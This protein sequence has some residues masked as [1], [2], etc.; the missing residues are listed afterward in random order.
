MSDKL[1]RRELSWL[2]TQEARGAAE[3]LRRGV[4]ILTAR[5]Q[6]ATPA[7]E[8][9]S[10]RPMTLSV[11]GEEGEGLESTLDMLD[12]AMQRLAELSGPTAGRPRRGRIDLAALLW[13]VAPGAKVQLEPGAGTTVLADE[14]ELRRMLHVLL[15]GSQQP[16]VG[17]AQRITLKREGDE[18]RLGVQL[19]PDVAPVSPAERGWLSRM[20]VRYGGRY[21]LDGSKE[22]VVFPALEADEAHEVQTL[23]RELEAAKAQ[24]EMYARELAAVFAEDPTRTEPPRVEPARAG[25]DATAGLQ[26]AARLADALADDLR[27]LF[28]PLGAARLRASQGGS[29]ADLLVEVERVLGRGAE[30]LALARH[31]ARIGSDPGAVPVDLA[32]LAR[33]EAAHSAVAFA[34]RGVALTIAPPDDPGSLRLHGFPAALRALVGEMLDLALRQSRAGDEVRVAVEGDGL[35]VERIGAGRGDEPWSRTGR[36]FLNDVARAHEIELHISDARI[37]ARVVRSASEG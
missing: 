27:A 19:G 2:L 17:G 8:H 15:G 4:Q 35:V 10:E 6:A 30:L 22:F 34:A 3:R 9:P 25:A 18:V 20:A 26:A 29:P 16:G 12:G 23:R 14:A 7:R 33:D 36:S 5:P 31:M 1:T 21:E 24:G 11:A 32:S 28:G 37:V 13:E